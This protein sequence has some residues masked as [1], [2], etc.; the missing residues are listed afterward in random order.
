MSELDLAARVLE[1]VRAASPAAE[2]EVSVDRTSSA[3]TRFANSVIHQNVAE[4]N[5]RVSVRVHVDGRTAS[6]ASTIT[7]DEG[8]AGLVGRTLAAAAIAPLDDGW[9]GLAPA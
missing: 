5:L 6:G 7:G 3:L 2:A 1:R 8:L 4:D 9:P